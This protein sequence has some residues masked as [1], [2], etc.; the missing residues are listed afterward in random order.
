[1]D[2]WLEERVSAPLDIA[3][4]TF[5]PTGK[6]AV[7]DP[8]R[9]AIY[10]PVF[11]VID[12]S[13]AVVSVAGKCDDADVE[14]VAAVL[15]EGTTFKLEV[16]TST[17]QIL[18]DDL[19]P[20]QLVEYRFAEDPTWR[21]SSIGDEA[22]RDFKAHKF[23]AWKDLLLNPTCEAQFRRMLQLGMVNKVFD[24]MI[25]VTPDELKA[26]YT[27]VDDNGKQV[28][29]PHPVSGLRVWS[30]ADMAY[31]EI[32]PILDGAPADEDAPA[33]WQRMLDEWRESRGEDY[34][35]GLL[36]ARA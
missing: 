19:S 13:E 34:I 22:L 29:I 16:L 2:G 17:C 36:G 35:N 20:S 18:Y 27:V 11:P 8:A 6:F 10:A 30:A 4:T 15:R 14:L 12:G 25:F 24:K 1:M 3:G 32:S 28:D 23:K 31:T 21:L 26:N 9:K 7:L 5:T 33:A